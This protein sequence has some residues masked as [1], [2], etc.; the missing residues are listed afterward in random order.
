M[1]KKP[2][3]R[4]SDRKSSIIDDIISARASSSAIKGAA[5]TR[6]YLERYFADVPV[7]DLA[8]RSPAIMARIALA[9]LEFAAKRRKG[10]ALLRIF[11]A[12][13]KT[14]GY[15]SPYTF[16]EMVNDD[17][18][19]LVDSVTAA[20]NSHD[21]A[22]HITVHPVFTVRRDS[23][24][25]LLAVARAGD[26]GTRKESFIRFAVDR[27]TDARVLK[28]LEREIRRV[29]AD[30][31]VAVRDW[32]KMRRRMVECNELMQLGPVG[33][34]E[35]L[36]SESRALLDWLV[37]DHFTFLG[38]R[39]YRLAKRGE[40]V[41][42]QPVPGTGLGLLSHDDR[43][44]HVTELTQEMRRLTR[45]KDWLIITKANSRSTIHRNAY[46]DYV[47]VKTYD[48]HGNACG[49]RRFIGLF[50]SVAYSESPR[51]IPLLRHKVTRILQRGDIDH[52]AHRGKALLHIIDTYPR[53]E[54]FQASVQ[55][56][57]RTTIGI[58]NL[59]DRQH[60]KFFLRRDT[61]RR[62]FSCLVYVPREKYTTAIRHKIEAILKE[63]LDGVSVDSSV[64]ISDSA[65]ARVHIV[66]H[67]TQGDRPRISIQKIERRI[68]AVVVTWA[69][70]LRVEI[71]ANY[72]PDEGPLLGTDSIPVR[73]KSFDLASGA[74][75]ILKLEAISESAAK[76]ELH[77]QI[78]LFSG[79]DPKDVKI[80][81]KETYFHA[82][83]GSKIHWVSKASGASSYND[84]RGAMA[85]KT[86]LKDHKKAVQAAL[87]HIERLKLV[88]LRDKE[89]LDILS[90][91]QVMN[92][93]VE[94]GKDEPFA[95]YGSDFYVVF[96]RRFDGTPVI[97]SHLQMRI[98][99]QR[100]LLG[101]KR[102]WR[103]IAGTLTDDVSIDE[104]LQ[105]RLTEEH[106][107]KRGIAES[108]KQLEQIEIVSRTC[109]YIE[110]SV[111]NEQESSGLGCLVNYKHR[112][113]EMI[114]ATA[115]TG[116]RPRE[117]RRL[118]FVPDSPACG[119]AQPSQ[120]KRF[121]S[122]A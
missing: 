99:K 94:D 49:E 30:V 82:D 111:N 116:S 34:D 44:G 114:A 14:H 60:V 40:N 20:I 85:E 39:E 98:G 4:G 6:Q 101:A 59:Q 46:L 90:V 47:G 104:P 10:Q 97:G 41:V 38:Y 64:Q 13:E 73:A 112:N 107:V 121:G 58:L 110:G 52:S 9:H 69:D 17:M 62:F 118:R 31:R 55:D 78:R 120:R 11:N 19:F 117:V 115:A 75:R 33:V 81:N 95:T 122:K 5:Q 50:T 54:L 37:A 65:L 87:E 67:T 93:L 80:Q 79:T 48:K 72:G 22:V 7:D 23:N 103:R 12:S 84:T 71:A 25:K 89:T 74:Y 29:L 88:E 91:S 66:I 1:S 96:G 70:R 24:G 53:D 42:L 105:K 113:E 106:L 119:V 68:A 3:R 76:S 36:R 56:L 83:S 27:E 28:R 63:S 26:A 2:Q 57:A 18:P 45:S 8:G 100:E 16:I 21:L 35:D 61:F 109:G 32:K 92:A 43:S 102:V 86:S 108:A 15:K 51:N 77:E